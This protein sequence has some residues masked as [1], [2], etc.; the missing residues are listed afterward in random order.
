MAMPEGAAFDKTEERRV[1]DNIVDIA[2]ENERYLRSHPE[3]TALLDHV[4]REVLLRRP[5][6]PV[7]YAEN[8]FATEDLPAIAERLR[9][10]GKFATPPSK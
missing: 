5:E 10:E 4:T 1:R 3:I 7:A 6:Q 2:I 8:F 9:K